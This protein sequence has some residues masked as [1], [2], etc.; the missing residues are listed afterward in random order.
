MNSSI[1][2]AL[3]LTWAIVLF[4]WIWSSKN[5]KK[6]IQTE[7]FL[8]RFYLYWIPQ[9]IA[10]ILLGP[11]DWFG[12][13]LIR[14]NFIEHTNMVGMIGLIICISGALLTC[15]SRYLLGPN[16]SATVQLKENHE[17]IKSGPYSYV[18]H[19]IYTGFLLLFI[20]NTL[21]VGDYRG[22]IAIAIVFISFLRKLKLEEKWLKIHFGENYVNYM[23]DTK[24]IIP[25]IL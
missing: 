6:S 1:K 12:H 20:G 24:A 18:R 9:I 4:Y 22:I 25:W 15:W 21:I 3:N 13:M 16:W 11:G 17:L 2:I 23:K 5:N 8:K 10:V 19:P 7:S 14:E